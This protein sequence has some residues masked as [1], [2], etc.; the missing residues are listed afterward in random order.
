MADAVRC[1]APAKINLALHVAGLRPDGYHEL[2]TLVAFAGIGDVI[3]V[4][5]AGLTSLQ[6]EGPFAKAAGDGPDNL[7]LRAE[8]ALRAAAGG[9]VA[10][11]AIRLQKRLPVG[12]GIGGGSADAAAT[13]LALAR[14]WELPSGFD[15]D[16][17]A[18]QLGADV[19]M[20][21]R[22][23]PLR[24]RG[25]GE[26]IET[27]SGME[28]IPVLLANPGVSASTPAVFRALQKRDNEPM[29]WNGGRFPGLATLASLRNDLQQPA[30]SLFP[31]IA[32]VLAMLDAAPGSLLARMSGSGSTCFALFAAMRDAEAAAEALRKS[33]P[34]WWCEATR[35]VADPRQERSALHL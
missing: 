5:P 31:E 32:D 11:V 13:L 25:R 33:R 19:P 2:D 15:L 21:L 34:H 16:P 29:G 7:V 6:V 8:A 24:A 35:L 12:G 30:V 14:L 17:I 27:L 18:L 3:E 1:F 23:T 26:R 28:P 9:D 22:S 10:P 20:C 4:R